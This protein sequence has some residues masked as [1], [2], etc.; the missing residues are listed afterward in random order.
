MIER[1]ENPGTEKINIAKTFGALL[2]KQF[3]KEANIL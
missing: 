3:Q 1:V 2:K